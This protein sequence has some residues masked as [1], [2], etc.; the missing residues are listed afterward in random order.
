MR[1]Q[2]ASLQEVKESLSQAESQEQQSG[3]G[4]E[5][6][7]SGRRPLSDPMATRSYETKIKG[8][9][10]KGKMI[11]DGYAP[12]ANFRKK[13]SAELSGEVRQAAQEA[14]EAIEQQRIP[15]AARDM[16]KGYFRNLAAGK[17]SPATKQP[18][19]P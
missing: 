15:R 12:G 13:T 16:A 10:D 11:F 2:L 7:G 1:E 9:F 5:G 6:I 14:P 19:K 17:E 18:A 4:G 3:P 8:N